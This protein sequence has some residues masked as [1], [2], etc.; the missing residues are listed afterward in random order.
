M[1]IL[2]FLTPKSEV[3][4]INEDATLFKTIQKMQERNYAAIPIVSKTGKYVGTITSG[5]ILGY[6]KE[7]FDLTLR[8]S[9]DIPL[10]NVRRVRDN[11]AVKADSKLEEIIDKILYQN[12]VPVVD[13]EERFIGIITRSEVIKWLHKRYLDSTTSPEQSDDK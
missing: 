1:N 3:D 11:K 13:D 5:D 6:I 9:A 8:D 4:Y 12:F 2:F 10:V 7:N